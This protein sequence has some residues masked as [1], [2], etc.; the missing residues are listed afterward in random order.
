MSRSWNPLKIKFDAKKKEMLHNRVLHS[1]A[2]IRAAKKAEEFLV[3][4]YFAKELTEFARQGN[5]WAKKKLEQNFGQGPA[6][7]APRKK[8]FDFSQRVIPAP[9]TKGQQHGR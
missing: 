4:H 1:G 8:L 7:R 5:P 3:R 6:L 2:S 9:R